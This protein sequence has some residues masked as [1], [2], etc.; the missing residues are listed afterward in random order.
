MERPWARNESNNVA[1][2][3]VVGERCSLLGAIYAMSSADSNQGHGRQLRLWLL[4]WPL[5]FGLA[6]TVKRGG[7]QQ[8]IF[9]APAWLLHDGAAGESHHLETSSRQPQQ[10][11]V[12]CAVQDPRLPR[13]GAPV[14]PITTI[15]AAS[16]PT[17]ASH[18]HVPDL[19]P[20]RL[21]H[22]VPVPVPVTLRPPSLHGGRR[23]APLMSLHAR[24]SLWI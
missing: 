23:R 8:Y 2:Q 15:R 21:Y 18:P 17:F 6:Q 24:R 16:S 13:G 1:V 14:Q 4:L 12:W 9:L 19:F 10:R 22:P 3:R 5:A 11:S 20:V 7:A